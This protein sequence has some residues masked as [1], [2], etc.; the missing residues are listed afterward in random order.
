[1]IKKSPQLDGVLMGLALG[2]GTLLVAAFA[3]LM[4]LV[5]PCG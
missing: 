2:L 1:M 4:L 3:V 5:L